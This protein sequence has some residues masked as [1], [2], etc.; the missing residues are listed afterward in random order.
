V[1]FEVEIL[2]T[3]WRLVE[4]SANKIYIFEL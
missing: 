4:F 1:D 2:L 3:K